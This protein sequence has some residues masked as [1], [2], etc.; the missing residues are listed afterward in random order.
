MNQGAHIVDL[1]LWFLGMPVEVS[2]KTTVAEAKERFSD[3][4]TYP[5]V[6]GSDAHGPDDIGKRF[7]WFTLEKGT[8]AE[9]GK[10]LAGRDNRK[11][12]C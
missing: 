11:T 9:L 12:E 4:R 7:T 2:A 3:C 8:V 6:T 5:V 10:A 1:L